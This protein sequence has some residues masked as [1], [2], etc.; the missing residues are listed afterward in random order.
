MAE[1]EKMSL[2]E[3]L[4]I[5]RRRKEETQTQA[6]KRLG[7]SYSRYSLWERDILADNV[8]D[9]IVP[10]NSL[11]P[12]EDCFIYRRRAKITQAKVAQDLDCCRNWVNLMERG[13]APVDTLKW[14]WEQ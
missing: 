12:F 4:I 6:A 7:V 1:I 13:L 14:Y 10:L 11:Q 2:G 8:P 5:D 9:I 3:S